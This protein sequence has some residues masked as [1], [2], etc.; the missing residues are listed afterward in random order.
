MLRLFAA[1]FTTLSITAVP[2]KSICV[3]RFIDQIPRIAMAIIIMV[4]PKSVIVAVFPLP[5]I[6]KSA[7]EQHEIEL[8]PYPSAIY[9]RPS[10]SP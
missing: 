9:N 10:R 1:L 5:Y 8:M 2:C 4:I 7:S 6:H 3:V